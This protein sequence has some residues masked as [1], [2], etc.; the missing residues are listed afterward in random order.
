[1]A[2]KI[3]ISRNYEE[4]EQQELVNQA[5]LKL[6]DNYRYPLILFYLEEKSYRDISDILHLSES[7]VGLRINRGK[8][9]L[10]KILEKKGINQ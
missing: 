5:L 7:N 9:N 8:K 4:K 2:A 6:S 1:M 10:K 3:D